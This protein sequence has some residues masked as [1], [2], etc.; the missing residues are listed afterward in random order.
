M[1][2]YRFLVHLPDTVVLLSPELKVLDATDEYFRVTMRT[3]ETLVGKD[4][5]SEF[6]NNPGEPE[7]MNEGRLRKSLEK[8]LQTKQPDF[9]DVLRYDIPSSD[10]SFDVRYWEAVHTPV[11]DEA[12]NIAFIIQKT[13]DVTEREL[14]KQALAVQESKFRFM[15]DAMPQLIFTTDPQGELTYLNQR[16]STYTGIPVEELL[17]HNWHQ[18]IHPGDLTAVSAKWQEAFE[19][20]REMQVEVRKLDRNGS[21]RWHLCRSLP[22]QDEQGNIIMWVGSST[23]IHETRLLVQELLTSNEQMVAMADQVQQAFQKA[24]VERR[25]MERLIQKAPFFCCVLKGPEHRFEL[26]NENYQM[27]MPG[28]EL[29]GKTVAEAMPEVVEQGFV[30][31]LDGVYRT[32]EEY[33]AENTPLKLDRY[34]TGNLEDIYV[35]FIYQAVRDEQDKVSGILVF[36]QDVTEQARLEQRARELGISIG[37]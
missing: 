17:Q 19:N 23:D 2:L 35:T 26:V 7:S 10:G 29:V 36:G 8:V 18:V 34:A 13:S 9:L 24:E 6:P 14:H 31:L 30:D 3:R 15:A 33:V 20:G 1:D 5:L 22:M 37:Q 32:G 21:Y 27:L 16:W 28:K 25:V 12:G 4:F 11:L